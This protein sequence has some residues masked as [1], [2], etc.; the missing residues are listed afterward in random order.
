MEGIKLFCLPYAGGSATVY[1][2]W[3]KYLDKDIKLCPIEMPGRSDR[4]T[5]PYYN[6]V[7]EAIDDITNIIMN[8]LEEESEYAIFG[9]S[10]GSIMAYEL[11]CRFKEKNLKPPMHVFFSGRYP[12]NIKKE[13]TYK[14]LLPD[15]EFEQEARRFGG[16]PENLFRFEG[17]LKTAM[18]TLRAD[19]KVI[20]TYESE[21]A[22]HKLNFNI[23]ALA[24]TEDVLATPVEMA[25]W[26]NYTDKQCAFYYFD[27]GHFYLHN[28]MEKITQIINNTLV[29]NR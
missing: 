13:R 28:H 21:P 19:Y 5:E 14:H 17:L 2:K 12:P 4:S 29:L 22:I 3:R 25:E 15:A 23:S 18:K 9:H 26:A 10:M 27:G 16:M 20:E 1:S 24:G 11:V 7:E 8:E 6:S